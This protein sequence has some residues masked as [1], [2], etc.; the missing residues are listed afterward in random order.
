V[1][2]GVR[3]P[4]VTVAL[5]V[6]EGK[7]LLQARRGEITIRDREGLVDLA[8]GGYGESE[9]EYSRLVGNSPDLGPT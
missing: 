5:Q 6:L 8:D 9:A 7:G 2:L 1:M 3:R 4:G